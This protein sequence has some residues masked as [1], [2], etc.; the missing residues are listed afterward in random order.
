MSRRTLSPS[1]G[2]VRHQITEI[3]DL[4]R[5]NFTFHKNFFKK[6]HVSSS[7]TSLQLTKNPGI[8][9]TIIRQKKIR[10]ESASIRENWVKILAN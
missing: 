3:L 9:V 6:V 2:H 5:K 8:F 10:P 1:L 7:E 4:V